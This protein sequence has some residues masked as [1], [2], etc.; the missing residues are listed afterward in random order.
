VPSTGLD[1]PEIRAAYITDVDGSYFAEEDGSEERR[2]EGDTS[3]RCVG[4][5]VLF[6]EA[7]DLRAAEA[8]YNELA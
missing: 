3:G 2:Y 6:S 7:L 4:F 8:L 5:G 1:V